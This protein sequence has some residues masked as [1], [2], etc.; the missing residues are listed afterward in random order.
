MMYTGI[1]GTLREVPSWNVCIGGTTRNIDYF[2]V[3]IDGTKYIIDLTQYV[4]ITI[5]CVNHY[6]ADQTATESASSKVYINSEVISLYNTMA[7]GVSTT[8]VEK[9]IRGEQLIT[10]DVRKTASAQTPVY[11][12][13]NLIYTGGSKSDDDP[14]LIQLTASGN[15]NIVMALTKTTVGGSYVAAQEINITGSA[16]VVS[17]PSS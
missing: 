14:R 7:S 17:L 2:L 4:D 10:I 3:G 11:L 9:V 1:N 6:G 8:N 15:I 16:V 5:S 13:N 12:N